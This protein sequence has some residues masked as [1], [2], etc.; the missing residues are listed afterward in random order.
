MLSLLVQS[1]LVKTRLEQAADGEGPPEPLLHTPTSS[2]PLPC[3]TGPE[4][5]AIKSMFGYASEEEKTRWPDPKRRPSLSI[6]TPAA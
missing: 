4:T 6:P 3:H 5:A 1:S 2:H